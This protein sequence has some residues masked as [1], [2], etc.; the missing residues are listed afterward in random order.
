MKLIKLFGYVFIAMSITLTSCSG[1]DG[2]QG[3]AGKNGDPGAQ[4]ATG[5]QGDPGQD[6]T[7][8]QGFDELAQYGFITLELEGVR[9]DGVAFTDS[10][11]FKFTNTQF[12]ETQTNEL[13][14]TEI[15]VDE[16]LYQSKIGRFLSAPDNAYQNT[17]IYME[18][19]I[20]NPGQDS[21]ALVQFNYGLTNY[22]VIGD[23]NKYF[24]LDHIYNGTDPE[25]QDLLVSDI[26]FEDADNHLTFSYAFTITATGNST[27]NPLNVSGIVDV[28]VLEQIQ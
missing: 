13:L 28:N 4:G 21:E 7:D 16:T 9:N 5:D 20:I 27:G 26:V 17:L 3:P 15:D 23:D 11:T 18:I 6:G 25:I 24:V 19:G 1:E 2:E 8:G 14:I 12:A 10:N 22:A